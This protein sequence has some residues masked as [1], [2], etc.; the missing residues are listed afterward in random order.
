MRKLTVN[1]KTN[2]KKVTASSGVD[3][4]AM[5]SLIEAM[6]TVVNVLDSMDED[7]YS[8]VEKVVGGSFYEDCS[9]S[10]YDLRHSF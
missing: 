5:R 1:P 2:N 7:T 3:T 9:D 8:A 4:N 6:T 10:L